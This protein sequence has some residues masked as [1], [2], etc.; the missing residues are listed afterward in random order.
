MSGTAIIDDL[1][2]R[3]LIHNHT[4]MSALASLLKTGP[5]T[6]YHG[7][8]PTSDCLH[9]GHL[10]GVLTLRRFQQAGNKPLVLIGG[11]TGMM[12]DPSGRSSERKL[13]DSD[14]VLANIQGIRSQLE[15]VDRF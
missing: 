8:D 11:A 7:I 5:I 12:G 3:G 13:I 10:V 1:K 2:L 9:I 4:D 15:K 6:L 14:T